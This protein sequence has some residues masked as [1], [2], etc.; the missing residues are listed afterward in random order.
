MCP[1]RPA[2]QLYA[3][4]VRVVIVLKRDPHPKQVSTSVIS[5]SHKRQVTPFKSAAFENSSIDFF[6]YLHLFKSR[7]IGL[8]ISARVSLGIVTNIPVTPCAV[9]KQMPAGKC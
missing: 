5:Y 2:S 1:A 8:C 3:H 9:S 7:G 6:A 4:L